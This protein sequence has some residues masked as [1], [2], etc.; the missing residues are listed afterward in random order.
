MK[1]HSSLAVIVATLLR[2]ALKQLGPQGMAG[3]RA[4]GLSLSGS[5]EFCG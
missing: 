3:V 5:L 1:S 4:W 2:T